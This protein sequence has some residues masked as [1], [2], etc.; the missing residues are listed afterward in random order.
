MALEQADVERIAH[1]ARIALGSEE[2]AALS[3]D[4]SGILEFVAQMDAVDTRGITPMAHPL[5]MAQRLR[6]DRVSE[7]DQRTLFQS[8]AP[9]AES[10]LYLVPKVIE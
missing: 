5:H 3:G 6:E 7:G 4:L 9:E 8:L 1:L 10:G 2:A